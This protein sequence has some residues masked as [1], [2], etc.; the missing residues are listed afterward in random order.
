MPLPASSA[1]TAPSPTK[2]TRRAVAAKRLTTTRPKSSR[3]SPT[4]TSPARADLLQEVHR[5]R[6]ENRQLWDWLEH[7][8]DCP[9]D[10][11]QQLTVTAAAMGLS[12]QQILTLLAI[13]LPVKVRPS[14]AT[15]GRWVQHGA[16]RAGRL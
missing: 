15:L 9:P 11:Q 1:R 13:L 3:P 10:K 4:P 6:D 2:P 14:R 5:L 16:Q 7:T 12:L 8:I